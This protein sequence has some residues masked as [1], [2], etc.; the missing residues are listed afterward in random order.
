MCLS[1][2]C[3]SRSTLYRAYGGDLPGPS[4]LDPLPAYAGFKPGS[5]PLIC[6]MDISAAKPLVD[7]I[8]GTVQ[9]GSILSYQQPP[10]SSEDCVI[11]HQ[12][13]P[14]FPKIP[15]EGYQLDPTD[16]A[17]VPTEQQQLHLRSLCVPWSQSHKIEEE[18]RCQSAA[19]VWHSLRKERVTASTFREI[20]HVKESTAETLAQRIIR[21][22]RQTAL[23]KRGLDL[24]TG[25]L[26][27]YATLK[28]TNI[29]RCGLV[30]HPDAPWLG[31]SPDGLV[32]DPL[33]RPSFGL[34][35]VKCPNAPSYLDCKYLRVDE[36]GTHQLK[37]SHAYYWQVQGQLLITGMEWCDFVICARDDMFVQRIYRNATVL[38]KL[39]RGCDLFFFYTYLSQYLVMHQ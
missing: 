29:R 4:T 38:D 17:F 35:E 18:T 20:C 25:A 13:A 24:E 37:E 27:D 22:T 15:L 12:D 10:A 5:T 8:F 23:M 14:P 31:A 1:L 32:Y 11:N 2:I 16:S 9:A 7:S 19:P 33:E 28:N 39:K 36:H 3:C 26:K 30:V 6:T 34:V 21:G